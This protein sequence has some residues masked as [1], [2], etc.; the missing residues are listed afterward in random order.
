MRGLALLAVGAG[1]ARAVTTTSAPAPGRPE[2]VD[3]TAA[4]TEVWRIT[5]EDHL[6]TNIYCELPYCSRDGRFLCCDD[7]EE[8][9]RLVLGS[10]RTGRTEVLCASRASRSGG[11][12]THPHACLTPT[13]TG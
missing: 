3:R 1:R 4:G 11:P 8:S 12:H 9:C 10:V 13:S 7:G 2:V 5:T 6:Q